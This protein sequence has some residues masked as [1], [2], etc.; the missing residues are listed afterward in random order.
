MNASPMGTPVRSRA[1]MHRPRLGCIHRDRLFAKNVFAG[2]SRFYCPG[3]MQVIGTGCG[4]GIDVGIGEQL[5][6]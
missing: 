4:Y 1:S 6:V 2:F 5:F 3:K